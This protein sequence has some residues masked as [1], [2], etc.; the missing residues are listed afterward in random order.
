MSIITKNRAGE[1]W[2]TNQNLLYN[3][4]FI[5]GTLLLHGQK[6]LLVLEQNSAQCWTNQT[7]QQRLLKLEESVVT[8]TV[9]L[10]EVQKER[11][12]CWW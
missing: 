7:R 2:I 8:V 12:S 11:Q 9:A 4:A 1:S 10:N 6:E 3:Y 5:L